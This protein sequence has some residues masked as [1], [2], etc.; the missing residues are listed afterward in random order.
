VSET[1]RS[2]T[3]WAVLGRRFDRREGEGVGGL[4]GSWW[5]LWSL[6]LA[7]CEGDGLKRIPFPD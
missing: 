1:L 4:T 7:R 3:L 2:L 5:V 6:F